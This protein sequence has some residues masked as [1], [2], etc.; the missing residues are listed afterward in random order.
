M[1][2]DVCVYKLVHIINAFIMKIYK[3]PL[4]LLSELKQL[5]EETRSKHFTIMKRN[6]SKSVYK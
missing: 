3:I 2:M 1:C 4:K 6:L 5:I